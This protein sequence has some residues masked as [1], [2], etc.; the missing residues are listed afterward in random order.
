LWVWRS[1]SAPVGL[2]SNTRA[3]ANALVLLLALL[4][5]LSLLSQ[6]TS[7]YTH[8]LS[9]WYDYIVQ[10]GGWGALKDDF[11]NYTPPYLY[12]LVIA[13][14]ILSFL[15]KLT[16]IKL[17]TFPFEALAALII[18]R[19]VKDRYPQG[20]WPRLAAFTFLFAPTVVLNGAYWGQCDIIYTTGLLGCLWGLAQRRYVWAWV[21]FGAAAAVKLQAVWLLPAL[22][23]GA[24]KGQFSWRQLG[25]VPLTY[26]AL[27]LPAALLGRPWGEL[28][29]IYWNQSQTFDRLSLNAPN[30]Y[31][32]VSN[33]NYGRILPWA[34]AL[35]GGLIALFIWVASKSSIPLTFPNWLKISLISLVL[36]PFLLPKMH[37]RYFFPADVVSLLYGFYFPPY[38]WVPLALNGISLFSYF[39]YLWG[40]APIP[41][42]VL[43]LLL[44]AVLL[45]LFA[46]LAAS[47]TESLDNR[48][49]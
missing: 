19:L 32:W 16:A 24:L 27:M 37:D 18:Y 47:E 44:G 21:S 42:T 2:L 12:G 49:P 15:P 30:L 46:H 31:Q 7:D 9:P 33:D 11:S 25:L 20:D 40:G 36:V 38:F 48:R 29:G 43:S 13:S 14:Q 10:Q 4:L 39:P 45:G 17:L 41:F 28:W 5:R 35:A 6:E 26:G 34:L 23:V 1:S 22:L 8:Y 3:L